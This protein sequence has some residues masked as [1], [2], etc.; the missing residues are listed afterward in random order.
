MRIV[1]VGGG[2][3]ATYMAN[4]IKTLSSQTDVLIVSE[5]QYAPYD[6]IHLCKL[7]E[8][9]SK[10]EEIQLPLDPTVGLELDQKIIK[11]D[12]KS[13]KIFSKK[14]MYAYDILILATGSVAKSPFDLNHIENASVFRS[15]DEAFKIAEQIKGRE[16]V[17][18]GAGP[19]SLE[20]LDTLDKVEDAKD[21]TLLVRGTTLYDKTLSPQSRKIMEE[22]YLKNGKI[23]ICY[24][25]VITDTQIEHG[26]ITLLKTTKHTFEDPF[27]IFGIGITPNIGPFKE[28]LECDRGILTDSY[29]QTSQADIYAV[30][31]CAQLRENGF[32]AGHVKACT[33]QADA[34]ISKILQ[35]DPRPFEP[36]ITIDMLKVG[37][38]DLV[39]VRSPRFGKEFEKI[40]ID[41][42]KDKRVDEYY[43]QENRLLRF[44]GLNSNM[45]IGYIEEIM[46]ENEEV[47]LKSFYENR[48]PNEKGRLVCSC[49]HLYYQDLV[50]L[51]AEN[52][53]RDFSELK[54]FSNAGRVCGKCRHTVEQIIQS[55]QKKIDP[56]MV[57]K[58]PEEIQREKV[59]K[60]IEKR[61]EKFNRL[62]PHN[63]L[64]KEH[65]ENALASMDIAQKEFNSWVSMVTASMQLHPNF[66]ESV[67]SALMTL[68]R[69]PIIWLELS[70]C[71]GN[72]EAFIKSTHPS[73]EELIFNYISLDY[74]ELIMSASGEESDTLLEKV[75]DEQKGKY[76]LIVE[77]AVPLGL[78][79]KYLRIGTKGET[80]VSLL[81]RC[82][83]EAA[84]VI[85][86]GS[87][88]FDGG[89]VA[90]A[91]N[92]TGAVG[93]GEALG[94]DDVINIPG[95]PANPVNIVGTLL[96]Y[97]MFEEFPGLDDQNRPLWAYE[98]RI[99]DNCERRGHYELGEFVRE[100]GDEGAKKGWCLFEMGCKGPYAFANCPTMKFN[101]STSWP[102]QAGHGCMACVEKQF[103]DKYAHERK[104]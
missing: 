72:S 46:E 20:L 48:L 59:L 42:E 10:I 4:R 39:D 25:D 78:E 51:V 12:S 7:I 97:L 76:V 101:D 104:I 64:S 100:W 60:K 61:I 77:G 16:V 82:A 68:N 81:K 31:E 74:H 47:D 34:A 88:A 3:A 19:I 87:C 35:R 89:V 70:D 9:R 5:E 71:S 96:H 41:S 14:N 45:D 93:V 52:G 84:M 50:N 79:G 55:A 94:R 44:I 8:K 62:H 86:V 1:I 23:R 15:A 43:L 69:I 95:C 102:V 40:L 67:G 80:G 53:I 58:T 13:K 11:I 66:E 103:F 57:R 26:R 83:R 27:L 29:M 2:I 21:I 56:D 73:I 63:Q 33:L 22:A 18:V 90:A 24:E 6:R 75:I 38:F 91:P 30:G 36:E 17:L 99:H 98:G 28:T 37:E 49:E 32:I 85:G 54:S 65:F 92:P